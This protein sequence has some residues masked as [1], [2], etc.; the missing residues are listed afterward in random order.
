VTQFP[1]LSDAK[2]AQFQIGASYAELRQLA[3]V[4][5]DLRRAPRAQG[6]D[7]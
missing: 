3:D 6:S 1:A 5:G 4:G 2:D 7:G